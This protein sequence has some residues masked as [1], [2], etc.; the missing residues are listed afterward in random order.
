MA[1]IKRDFDT[2][3]VRP[4]ETGSFDT[5]LG[6]LGLPPYSRN[7]ECLQIKGDPRLANPYNGQSYLPY[8]S[9]RLDMPHDPPHERPWIK[10]QIGNLVSGSRPMN[11]FVQSYYMDGKLPG[12]ATGATPE[13]MGYFTPAEIP[14]TDFFAQKFTVCDHWFSSIPASTQPNRLMAMAGYTLIDRNADVLKDQ[15]LVYDWLNDHRVSWRVYHEG[16]PFFA[17]MPRVVPDLLGPHFRG[18]DQLAN[19]F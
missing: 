11:G 2:V 7:I 13:V 8:H 1:D 5:M 12:P 14:V 19:D 3:I 9:I 18:L 16:I 15:Y 17:L 10:E 6:Y 4:M